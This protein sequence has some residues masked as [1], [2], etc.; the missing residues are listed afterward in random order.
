MS[1]RGFQIVETCETKE[2]GHR[3][4]KKYVVLPSICG[5]EADFFTQRKQLEKAQQKQLELREWLG[6]R[7]DLSATERMA[8]NWNKPEQCLKYCLEESEAAEATLH[9]DRKYGWNN[10]TNKYQTM[11]AGVMG[12]LRDWE[13]IIDIVKKNGGPFGDLFVGTVSM[14][15]LVSIQVIMWIMS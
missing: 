10:W 5:L 4:I 11:G 7:K 15:F 12:F 3:S 1:K 13:P 6:Q 8:L 9:K 14:L 2:P